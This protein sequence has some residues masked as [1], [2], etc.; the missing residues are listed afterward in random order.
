MAAAKKRVIE[1]TTPEKLTAIEK[2]GR[3]VVEDVQPEKLSDWI[4]YLW[5]SKHTAVYY[6]AARAEGQ[7]WG[8]GFKAEKEKL[9][10]TD[11]KTHWKAR[12][13]AVVAVNNTLNVLEMY[14]KKVLDSKGNIDGKKVRD[15]ERL[16]SWFQAL[17][18]IR[19]FPIVE[20]TEQ[21][22]KNMK[23]I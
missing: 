21:E 23:L 2:K 19:K 7:I 15:Q 10:D 9:K 14:G 17:R 1:K 22:A 4:I 12:K 20:I 18:K 13:S 5:F 8:S 6:A 11:T 16:H 3:V